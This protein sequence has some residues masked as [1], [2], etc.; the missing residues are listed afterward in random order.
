MPLHIS[1]LVNKLVNAG[2]HE[3]HKYAFSELGITMPDH[4]ADI[5]LDMPGGQHILLQFRIESPSI[6]IILPEPVVAQS[7]RDDELT[8]AEPTTR[9]KKGRHVL[10]VKQVCFDLPLGVLKPRGS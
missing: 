5:T 8:P 2:P 3:S 1:K 6:D 7:W 4:D 9:H 10:R